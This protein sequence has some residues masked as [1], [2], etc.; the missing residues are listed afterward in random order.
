M[1]AKI[2]V[3]QADK[4]GTTALSWAAQKGH[5]DIVTLLLGHAKI[6]VNQADKYGNS[7]LSIAWTKDRVDI[8]TLL[9]GHAKTS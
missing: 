5:A 7:P 1:Q 6:D 9:L 8:V 4:D 3:N 2:D